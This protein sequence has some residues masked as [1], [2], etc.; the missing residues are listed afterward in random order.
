MT[1]RTTTTLFITSMLGALLFLSG[2]LEGSAVRTGIY[3]PP[4][5]DYAPI[6]VYM[7]ADPYDPWDEVGKV[8]AKGTGSHADLHDVIAVLKDQA[9]SLGAD[10]VIVTESWSE[11][12]VWYDEYGYEQVFTRTY[13]KGIAIYYL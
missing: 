8:S 5:S 6:D 9:R 7:N 12:D 2:C 4:K 11:D 13:A 3:L 1:S 10:G